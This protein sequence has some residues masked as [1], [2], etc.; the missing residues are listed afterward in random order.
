MAR[1]R[2]SHKRPGRKDMQFGSVILSLFYAIL[3]WAASFI[4]FH[5]VH[6]ILLC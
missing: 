4:L 5:T 1:F 6:I 3:L 2:V